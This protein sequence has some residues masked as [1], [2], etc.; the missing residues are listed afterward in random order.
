MI[1]SLCLSNNRGDIPSKAGQPPTNP[2]D[3]PYTSSIYA[4]INFTQPFH[5]SY[6]NTDLIYTSLI[7]I[8]SFLLIYIYFIIPFYQCHFNPKVQYMLVSHVS[9][10]DCFP[11]FIYFSFFKKYCN[12]K[13]YG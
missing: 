4:N 1:L 12:M 6:N 9:T 3:T 5:C 2:L 13:C 10:Y 8:C 11:F 7:C